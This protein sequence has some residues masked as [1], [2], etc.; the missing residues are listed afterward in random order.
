MPTWKML[1]LV[2]CLLSF[3]TLLTLIDDLRG[4]YRW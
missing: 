4:D 3:A 1:L 2:L